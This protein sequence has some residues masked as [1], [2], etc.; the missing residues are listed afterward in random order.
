M[1]LSDG[2]VQR[3]KAL[4]NSDGVIAAAAIDQR[5]TLETMMAAAG[6]GSLPDAAKMSEFK[7]AVVRVLSPY[8][9]AML[10]DT[11]FGLP[12]VPQ[13]APGC[14]LLLTYERFGYDP[15]V[16]GRIPELLEHLSVRRMVEMGAQGIKILLHY[17]PFED[18]EINDRKH[19]WVERIGAGMRI[20]P[21]SVLSRVRWLRSVGR[22][23]EYGRVRATQA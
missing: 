9:S 5:G 23:H 20:E 17:T 16:P 2:K 12:A 18:P 14:G 7:S 8:T 21:G 1:T 22:R 6:D 3:L 4:A 13:R 19:A 10:I 11:D 15:N